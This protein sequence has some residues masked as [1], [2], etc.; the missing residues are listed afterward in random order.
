MDKNVTINDLA[1][2]LGMSRNTVSKALNGKHVPTKTRNAVISAA[3]EMGYKGYKLAA[4]TEG[5]SLM[6]KRILI[7]SARLLLSIS[8]HIYVLRGIEDAL[9][10]YDVDLVQFSITS[11]ASFAKLKRYISANKVDGIIAMEFFEPDYIAE[12]SDSGI[13]MVFLDFP[14]SSSPIRGHYDLILP[15]SRDV[16]MQL[17]SHLIEADQC[18]TFGF[19]GDF[20]HCKS[21]FERYC[22][23]LEAQFINGIPATPHFSITHDDSLTYSPGVLTN[24]IQALPG[25][26][27]CF[28]AAND[29]IAL[30]L[31]TA[32]KNLKIPVP[33]EVRVI[34][35]D[36]SPEGKV[37]TPALT[38][39]NVNK[40]AMG[41]QIVSVLLDRMNS[42][43][44]AN[45]TI[46]IS[47]KPLVRSS[48]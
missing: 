39:V 3:I 23:M 20:H 27:D 14:F 43:A 48:T 38:T 21:F 46:Y 26:P 12:L 44:R 28:V 1:N 29:Y 37:S 11:S 13:P 19:V 5:S 7:L 15:E 30:N 34:G 24:A 9:S 47:S 25:L 17:C 10:E 36:N 31:M 41:K 4:S 40:Y 33:K 8:Y 32:L 42:P 2:A 22:G 6:Q 16:L 35:F 45:N 18:K